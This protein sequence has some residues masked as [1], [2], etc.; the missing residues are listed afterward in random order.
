MGHGGRREIRLGEVNLVLVPLLIAPS[1]V[2]I[3]GF[4]CV[5]KGVNNGQADRVLGVIIGM[6]P[7]AML[8]MSSGYLLKKGS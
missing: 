1:F 4:L 6:M 5:E 2:A 8:R 3:V 7:A